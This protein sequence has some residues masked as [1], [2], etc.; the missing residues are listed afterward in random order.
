[1][2]DISQSFFYFDKSANRQRVSDYLDAVRAL[3]LTGNDGDAAL[4]AEDDFGKASLMLET[5]FD[6][7]ACSRLFVSPQGIPDHDFYE[8]I[9][10]E[11]LL[12]LV[13]PGE[14]DAYRRIPLSDPTLW[15]RMRET[16]Q[17]GFRFILPPPITGGT[18]QAVRVAV[19]ASDFTVIVWWANA[20][21]KAAERLAAMRQFLERQPGRRHLDG[22]R[23]PPELDRNPEFLALRRDLEKAMVKAIK[24]NTSTFD[25]PWGLIALHRASAGTA[26]AVATLISPKLTLFLPE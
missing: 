17:P 18:D 2:Q 21:A 16:G 12:S 20:M 14:P 15:K 23:L 6:D 26:T 7:D 10:R 24:N 3:G 8:R 25:D 9:G 22:D 4:G 5:T 19:V 11:A 13:K 1:V